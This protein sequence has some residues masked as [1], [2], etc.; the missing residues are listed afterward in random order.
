MTVYVVQEKPG[1]DMTDA[2]RFGDFQELLPRKDQLVI[3]S[4]PVIHSLRKKLRDFSDED[5]IL[6]LGDPSIIAVV[7]AVASDLNRGRFKLLKWDR[8]LEKYYPVEVNIN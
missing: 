1:V 2:L 4:K 3:S 8:R 6:C 7:A 5:Y